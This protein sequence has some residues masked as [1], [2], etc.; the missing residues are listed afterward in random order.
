MPEKRIYKRRNLICY[1]KVV[2]RD[3][4]T[5]IGH[6]VDITPEGIMIMS[7]TPIEAEKNYYFRVLI[8]RSPKDKE[9]IDV[10]GKSKWCR[11][12]EGANFF[13]SG[14]ELRGISPENRAKIE[15]VIENL[16]VS[17]S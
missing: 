11:K 5:L 15:S 3:S 10:E 4:G 7:E 2:D 17:E 14:F 13:D 9:Y 1:L 8:E 16:C 6:L 12:E